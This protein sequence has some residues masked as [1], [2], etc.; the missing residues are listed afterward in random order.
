VRRLVGLAICVVGLLTLELQANDPDPQ[1]LDEVEA[2]ILSI[3]E[4]NNTPGF[5]GAL[6]IGDEVTWTSTLGMSDV[7]SQ[8][9][10]VEDTQFRVVS[11]SKTITALAAPVLLEQNVLTLDMILHTLIPEAAIGKA[12]WAHAQLVV[13]TAN[14]I[15]LGYLSYYGLIGL[16]FW[17]D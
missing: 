16:R 10:V 3:L 15:V 11:I 1:T 9:A 12:V 13:T 7:T 6:V 14:V 17:A 8:R 5:I 2:K 4:G